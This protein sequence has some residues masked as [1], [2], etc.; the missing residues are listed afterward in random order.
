MLTWILGRA[1]GDALGVKAA[2]KGWLR[3]RSV[4]VLRAALV[5]EVTAAMDAEA[6]RVALGAHWRRV[7]RAWQAARQLGT[8]GDELRD[9][10]EAQ[11]RVF[12][13]AALCDVPLVGLGLRQ[14]AEF[15]DAPVWAGT[16]G[17]IIEAAHAFDAGGIPF[18][19]LLGV[20]ADR[21]L[22]RRRILTAALSC[23]ALAGAFALYRVIGSHGVTWNI[24]GL[25]LIGGALFGADA[26]VSGSASQD[27]G[28][29][30]ASALACG[31]VNGIGSIGGV[32]QTFLLVYVT[33]TYGW[34][35]LFQVF[36]G[37]SLAAALVL[38]PFV[39]VR[40][41]IPAAA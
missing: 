2:G 5:D 23:L 10:M 25:M 7:Y 18:V 6:A 32:V 1:I 39:R 31:L 33:D 8:A 15:D 3:R 4:M 19:I 21:V 36:I 11:L 12:D 26:L 27:V 9:S 22:G 35:V 24:I 41:E 34:D 38:A 13:G 37:L 40:P 30:H 20:V 14:V 17:M 28:G 16:P 29:S